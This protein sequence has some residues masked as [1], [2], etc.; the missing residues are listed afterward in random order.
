L[1][2]SIVSTDATEFRLSFILHDYA[3]DVV[4]GLYLVLRHPGLL[5]I[6]EWS[7][8]DTET[9]F[10]VGIELFDEDSRD[11]GFAYFIPLHQSLGTILKAAHL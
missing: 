9:G 4:L 2:T 5:T 1:L 10:V 3:I 8:A 6:D 11:F 7:E